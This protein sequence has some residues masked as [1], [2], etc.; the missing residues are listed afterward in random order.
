MRSLPLPLT[1][2][3]SSKMLIQNSDDF[4]VSHPLPAREQTRHPLAMLSSSKS[5]VWEK[6]LGG[7]V[8]GNT[9][10]CGVEIHVGNEGKL[11]MLPSLAGTSLPSGLQP[12]VLQNPQDNNSFVYLATLNKHFQQHTANRSRYVDVRSWKQEARAE[13]RP[14]GNCLLH[15]LGAI[16]LHI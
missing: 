7:G 1:I 12:L 15:S 13:L 16:K 11:K 6:A 5:S 3:P 8:G 4:G 10:P 2:S 14:S 9:K